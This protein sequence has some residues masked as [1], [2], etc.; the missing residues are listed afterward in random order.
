MIGLACRI[1]LLALETC[2]WMQTV[3]TLSQWL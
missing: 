2:A 3:S 1:K